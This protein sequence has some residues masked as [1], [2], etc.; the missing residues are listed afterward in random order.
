MLLDVAERPKSLSGFVGE[1][2][3]LPPVRRH[4]HFPVG[5]G[6][7]TKPLQQSRLLVRQIDGLPGVT[8]Q[9]VEF[10]RLRQGLLVLDA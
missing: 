1:G 2:L 7:G 10:F 6:R 3:G 8:G 9:V 5:I 4:P